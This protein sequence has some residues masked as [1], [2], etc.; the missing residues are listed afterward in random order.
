MLHLV[1]CYQMPPLY[2]DLS[3]PCVP[4]RVTRGAVIAYRCMILLAAEPRSTAGLLLTCQYL[5]N[6]HGDPVLD[7]AGLAGLKSRANAFLLISCSLHF[8]LLLFS[9][10]LVSF[11][12]LV[13]CGWGLQTDSV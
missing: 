2:G 8:C 9:L 6:D 3:E 10:S 12:G 5:W 11:Y 7:G 1:I 4:V 13:F